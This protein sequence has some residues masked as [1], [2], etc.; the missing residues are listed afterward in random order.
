MNGRV[1]SVC[2]ALHVIMCCREYIANIAVGVSKTRAFLSA[3]KG[4]D[5]G[6]RM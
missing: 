4:R 3:V 5:K 6:R 1:L 2:C